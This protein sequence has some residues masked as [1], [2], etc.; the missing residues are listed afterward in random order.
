MTSSTDLFIPL[1][2]ACA[3]ALAVP[4]ALGV[5]PIYDTLR[6]RDALPDALVGRLRHHGMRETC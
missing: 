2:T 5:A 4:F 1:L 3:A 6:A